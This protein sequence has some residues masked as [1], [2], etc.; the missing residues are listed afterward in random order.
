MPASGSSAPNSETR[1]ARRRAAGVRA[2]WIW[3]GVL[4][5]LA[6]VYGICYLIL[7]ARREGDWERE[8]NAALNNRDAV[9]AAALLRA[10]RRDRPALVQSP[11]F[12]VWESRLL[13]IQESNARRLAAFEKRLQELRD[14]LERERWQDKAFPLELAEAAKLAP[15]EAALDQ[16]SELRLRYEALA[17]A[18]T[19]A[20]AQAGAAALEDVRSG[21]RELAELRGRN[22]WPL[23][24]KRSALLRD[25]L[26]AVRLQY[27]DLPELSD[28][29]RSLQ[30]RWREEQDA[31]RAAQAAFEQENA[32]FETVLAGGFHEE[33]A[34]R[35]RRFLAEHPRSTHVPELQG[36][37]RELDVLNTPWRG[38]I[39]SELERLRQCAADAMAI[40][41]TGLLKLDAEYLTPTLYELAVRGPNQAIR[42]Y[43]TAERAAFTAPDA[44]GRVRI[45]FTTVGNETV[46]G[47]FSDGGSGVLSVNNQSSRVALV[48]PGAPRNYLEPALYQERLRS[49]RTQLQ[50]LNTADFPVWL[51]GVAAMLRTDASTMP[52]ALRR[53]LAEWVRQAARALEPDARQPRSEPGRRHELKRKILAECTMHTPVFAG[54]IRYDATGKLRFFPAG[55]PRQRSD[56]WTV[57][58]NGKTP[59][60]QA[61]GEL[62]EMR[63]F[64]SAAWDG[65]ARVRAVLAPQSDWVVAE[66]RASWNKL[67][68]EDPAL[69]PKLPAFVPAP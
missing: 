22:D 69:L 64:P 23:Y 13:E 38:E 68:G 57:D 31:G 15:D 45:A 34:R 61:F 2:A 62:R 29:V 28:A 63:L 26:E 54:L 47:E 3:G 1:P 42:R 20:A 48:M 35:A 19:L 18:R 7:D 30:H 56:A 8:I 66:R 6:I 16:L 50:T 59:R 49:M 9:R 52:E 53:D 44:A 46:R 25:R 41:R 21:L 33:I 32:D 37:L 10:G 65:T 43:W 40:F 60:F 36:L 11:H 55:I 67:A 58:A 51:D 24:D 27:P 14:A 5:V 12:A 4:T 17:K 39:E